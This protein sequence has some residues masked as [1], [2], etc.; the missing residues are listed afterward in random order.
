MKKQIN[1][2][3]FMMIRISIYSFKKENEKPEP[4]TPGTY[5]N[6]SQ[7]KAGNYWI[8]QQYHI[9]SLDN[10]TPTTKYDSCY[11]E[12]DKKKAKIFLV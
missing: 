2:L 12:K 4:D 10:A 6:Y 3:S 8:Y 9:D 7:L 11:V 1:L 5:P